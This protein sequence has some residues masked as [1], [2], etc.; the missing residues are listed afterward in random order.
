MKK[1]SSFAFSIVTSVLLFGYLVTPLQGLQCSQN[2]SSYGTVVSRPLRL[3]TEGRWIKDSSGNPVRLIGAAVY[4]RWQW[5]SEERDFN[6]LNYIDETPEKYDV[7]K[8]TG[9]NFLRVNLNKWLW[10]NAF[11][12]V[13]AVDTL[14]EW[15]DNRSIM[16]VLTFMSWHDCREWREWTDVEKIEY[17][18]NGS[19]RDFMSVLAD[20][21]KDDE[22]V[23]GL[24][25]MP[26]RPLP[27]FWASYR[28]ITVAQARSEYRQGMISAIKAIHAIDP[29][30][31]VFIYPLD[32]DNLKHFVE[33][34]PIDEPNFVYSLMRSVSWDKGWWEYADAYYEGKLEEGYALMEQAYE[35]WLFDILDL[36]YPAMLL[37]T[38]VWNDLP[39]V[40]RYVD[41][42]LSLFERRNTSICW[43]PYDRQRTTWKCLFLLEATEELKPTLSEIGV[44]WAQHM[45]N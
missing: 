21:Y 13:R 42:L 5:V 18:V 22:T 2:I 40:T 17:V 7:Y 20:R 3:H 11:E 24:E 27:T 15:C 12:Y 35:S 14:I 9:A 39:N 23:I 31:L 30:Y 28:N 19:M 6:P 32:D 8:D 29:T 33:E 16:V 44:I 1:V 38:E 10:D 25:I 37:E 45:K 34:D 4:W 43:W 41:D 26:E 36:G